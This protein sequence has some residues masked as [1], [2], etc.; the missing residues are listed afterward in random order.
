MEYVGLDTVQ[1]VAIR[2]ALVSLR[3]RGT[4]FAWG[5]VTEE[6][7]RLSHPK[8]RIMPE[9]EEAA[10]AYA[11]EI[12]TPESQQ[13]DSVM[14]QA[15]WEAPVTYTVIDEGMVIQ[16][17]GN[18]LLVIPPDTFPDV[19]ARLAMVLRAREENRDE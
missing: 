11:Y 8:R 13:P 9:Q 15:S 1:K 3:A 2:Q 16:Q 6:A 4:P 18:R 5:A 10:V 19:I 12:G 7:N 17:G 14:P